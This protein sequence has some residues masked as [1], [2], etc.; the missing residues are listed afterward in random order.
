[1][2]LD[3]DMG[4]L[5]KLQETPTDQL[6]AASQKANANVKGEGARPMVDGRLVLHQPLSPEG[7]AMHASMPTI[8]SATSTEAAFVLAF[9]KRNFQVT[10]DQ[11]R[12]RIAS[13][14][15]LDEARAR[16]VMAGY[17]QDDPQR[18]PWEVLLAAASEVWVRAAMHR[19]IEANAAVRRAPV[20]ML[21]FNYK[22]DPVLGAAHAADIPYAFGN[23]VSGD[24]TYGLYIPDTRPAGAT[25]AANMMSTFVAF[26]RTGNPN[27]PRIPT[28]RPYDLDR[29]ATLVMEEKP[30]VVD[31]FRSGDRKTS[32]SL[33][34]QDPGSAGRGALFRYE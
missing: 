1:M 10:T 2:L 27:N 3:I 12:A 20:Y 24:N 16:E 4:D 31:D 34:P 11:V 21:D 32:A 23:Q 9:D 29:R 15:Q 26:A 13:Q 6:Y 7:L 25:V 14:Y 17:A 33:P 19:G 22:V 30:R 5:R 8:L 18:S 28:W